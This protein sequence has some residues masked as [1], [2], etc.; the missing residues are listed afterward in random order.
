[1]AELLTVINDLNT[2][3]QCSDDLIN[4]V[5]SLEMDVIKRQGKSWRHWNISWD[6]GRV[7]SGMVLFPKRSC[8]EVSSKQSFKWANGRVLRKYTAD[9]KNAEPK[10]AKYN[11]KQTNQ[12]W[13]WKKSIGQELGKEIA[14]ECTEGYLLLILPHVR[15]LTLETYC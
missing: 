13:M 7:V 1:M 14:E 5:L 11:K 2:G 12:E 15:Y 6:H 3:T 8:Q 4:W 10:R 9:I